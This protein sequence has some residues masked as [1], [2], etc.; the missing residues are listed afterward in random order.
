MKSGKW[1][2]A[3]EVTTDALKQDPKNVKALMRRAKSYIQ[4]KKLILAEH[5]VTAGLALA[6]DSE[7]QGRRKGF[8]SVVARRNRSPRLRSAAAQGV[9]GRIRQAIHGQAG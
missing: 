5:D 1:Q 3:V 2:R 9:P 4:L 7:W 6:P 8:F